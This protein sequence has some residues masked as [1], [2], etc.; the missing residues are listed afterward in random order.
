M[1]GGPGHRLDGLKTRRIAGALSIG[2]LA[3]RANISDLLVN[4]LESGGNCDPEET[5][6]ILSALASPVSVT[7]SSIAN[8]SQITVAT[9]TFVTG[10][11]VTIAG[12]SGSIPSINATHVVTVINSTTFSIPVNVTGGGTGGTATLA[13]ASVSLASLS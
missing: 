11:S 5:G 13:T 2:E 10:D 4:E 8:P 9:H 12:H 6:R 1:A 7:S 3:R